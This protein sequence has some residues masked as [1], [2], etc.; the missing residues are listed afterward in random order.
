[1]L[2]SDISAVAINDPNLNDVLVY[3][4]DNNLILENFSVKGETF[5]LKIYNNMGQLVYSRPNIFLI[6]NIE[7][8]SLDNF[9]I[10]VYNIVVET[11]KNYTTYRF[12]KS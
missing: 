7:M 5:N 9:G 12:I 1:M 2:Y 10:G 4:K 3:T 8:L 11:D 6:S